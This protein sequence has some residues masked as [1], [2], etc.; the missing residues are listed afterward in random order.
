VNDPFVWGSLVQSLPDG[1]MFLAGSD[2]TDFALQRLLPDG[3]FAPSADSMIPD[4]TSDEGD[5]AD[6]PDGDGGDDPSDPADLATAPPIDLSADFPFSATNPGLFDDADDA[7]V[8]DPTGES[9][10]YA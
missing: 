1:S 8:F 3:S 6:S 5:G 10:V 7:S 4:P 9:Q 2:Y